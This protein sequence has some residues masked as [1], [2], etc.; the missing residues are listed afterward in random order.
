L[1]LVVAFGVLRRPPVV[2]VAQVREARPGEEAT[3]LTAAGYVASERRSTVAP[4]IA[5]RLV[6]VS[7]KE[8]E[9]VEEGAVLARLDDRD[10][11]VALSQA[12]AQARAA[13][14]QLG[15]ARAQNAK[16]ARDLG[17]ATRLAQS[18]A[19][20]ATALLDARSQAKSADESERAA[21]AQSRATADAVLAAR[22][23]L[24]DTV[25]RA[26]F[27][28]TISK[29]LADEGA[30]LAPA[31]VSDIN[32][33]GIVELVDLGSL[34]VEAELSED[35]IANVHEGQ[36]ALIFLDA[37][38]QRV[39]Q[40]TTGTIRPTIDRAKATAVVKVPFAVPP[41]GVY[42]NM[43]AKVSFLEHPVDPKQLEEEPRLRV[44]R[45]ALFKANGHDAVFIVREGR[46]KTAW[47]TV[48]RESGNELALRDGP[49]PGTQIVSAPSRKLRDGQ[50]VRVATG[51]T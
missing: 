3:E 26:P 36:P 45:S 28:G 8:G 49:P 30:V 1:L 39:Y 41:D 13:D 38:P 37:Y 47:V 34:N 51:A 19:I 23:R 4:K 15:V 46:L 9:R 11:K 33:G 43:G 31:A 32:V 2:G 25:I 42:P 22:I 29:K 40:A 5:G 21:L 44:P 16:A 12:E 18:G 35:R 27:S 10:A 48:A 6:E 50:R 17:Q 14:A 7:V 24:D 20:S